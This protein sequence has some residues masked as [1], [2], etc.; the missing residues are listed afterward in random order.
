[1]L[2][3]VFS[4]GS[5]VSVSD[6]LTLGRDPDNVVQL[7][8]PSVSRHHARITVADGAVRLED[9]RSRHGTYVDGRLVRAPE[10]LR[11]GAEIRLG[12]TELRVERGRASD[13][14]GQTVVRPAAAPTP[15]LPVDR[16][17]L[18]DGWALKR[19]D[20]SEGARRYIL[21]DPGSGELV[22]MT[23]DEA[24]LLLLLDGRRELVEL[25]GEAERRVGSAGPG[26][27]ARLMA[28]LAN[29]GLLEGTEAAPVRH[30]LI[31]RVAGPHVLASDRVGPLVDR[32]YAAGGY[33]A[34]TRPVVAVAGLVALAGPVAMLAL[35]VEDSVTPF[36][37]SAALPLG[38]LAFLVGRFVVVALH[39]LAHALAVAAVGRSVRRAGLKIVLVF[40]YAFVDTSEG[41]FE[42]RLR[43]MLIS[44]AG[45]FSDLFLGGAFALL[46]LVAGGTAASVVFQLAL[47]AYLGAFFNLNPLLDRDGYHLL[48]DAL[49]EPNLRTRSRAHLAGASEADAPRPRLLAIY[50]V[51][52]LLWS[53][54]GAAIVAVFA[55][56]YADRLER[57]APPGVVYALIGACVLAC[58]LPFVVGVARL[59]HDRRHGGLAT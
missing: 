55:L 11:D 54:V 43:R 42:S 5:R 41:W 33:L 31:R 12:D 1:V 45:P 14:A 36:V 39:E 8:D 15:M 28:D 44:A 29:R 6:A 32:V 37:V 22:R 38:V 25:V 35:M 49:R 52:A 23:E 24:S 26:V 27:L 3:L 58:A 46:A 57:I 7:A 19:L 10:A 47:A 48:V 50:G 21:R 9:V 20:A 56:R 51:A 16:P 53:L 2:E 40:P 59:V 30:G 18:R 4:D 34:F 13:E 17:S